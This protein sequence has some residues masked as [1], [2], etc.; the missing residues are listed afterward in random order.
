M[1]Q[2]AVGQRSAHSPQ[3]TQTS[4]SFTITRPVCGSAPDTN[5]VLLRVDGRRRQPLRRS[6]SSPLGAMV[7]QSV[8]QM[9][10]QASHSMHFAS[11]NTVCTSQLRQRSTS[12]AVCSAIEA[13]LDLERELLEPLAQ[14]DVLHLR[15]L[16][17]VVVVAVAPLGQPHLLGDEVHPLRQALGHR[18]RRGSGCGSR[19]PPRGACA[20]AQMMFF[21]PERR[22]AA[23]EHAR[24]GSTAS[25]P[26]RRPACPHLSNSMPDVAL[27]PGERV[28]LADRQDHVV[29]REASRCRSR[30]RLAAVRVVVATR[31]RS[32]S[33]PFELAV[34]DAR[35]AW[36]RG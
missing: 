20:T 33:M 35:S 11:V 21:G 13:Q 24:A 7:R 12:R 23:E 27:D 5:S 26:R 10:M 15:A 32:N 14:V 1:S 9:S 28:L 16:G 29:G 19:S 2:A 25:S 8:G 6:S 34:L 17:R 3:C 4:S 31:R 36:A 22:V 18:R 30:R